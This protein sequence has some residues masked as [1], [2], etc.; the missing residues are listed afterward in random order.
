MASIDGLYCI[1]RYEASLV[2]VLDDGREVA[3]SP[4]E[5]V[6]G[7]RV[8]AVSRSNVTPQGYISGKEAARACAASGKRLCK[9]REWLKAC[10]GPEKKKYGYSD[11]NEPRRCNDYGRSPLGAYLRAGGKLTGDS[12]WTWGT[13]NE[14]ALNQFDRTLAPTGSHRECTNGYGVYDM[15]GNL[16]EWVDEARGM[17][18]GGYYQDTH[19]NGDGC[20]YRTKAHPTTYHDY[21]TGFR[22]CSDA[23]DVVS[24]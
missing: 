8:R 20:S 13:M 7:R 21:S 17:F 23:D 22:C 14:P 24:R 10:M 15:V 19:I 1:D 18:R 3:W 5:S 4:F 2:E 9:S 11:N 16:H 12:L 6:E